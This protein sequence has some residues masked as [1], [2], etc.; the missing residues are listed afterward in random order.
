MSPD[1][2]IREHGYSNSFKD[3]HTAVDV[4]FTRSPRLANND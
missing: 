4:R 2:Q 1:A 3:I